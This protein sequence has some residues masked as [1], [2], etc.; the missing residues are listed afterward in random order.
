MSEQLKPCPFCKGKAR[1]DYI[2]GGTTIIECSECHAQTGFMD[3]RAEATEAWNRRAIHE[4]RKCGGEMQP[5]QAIAQTYTGH[6]DFIG[7]EAVTLSPGG[8]GKLVE[9]SKCSAC[10]WSVEK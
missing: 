3:S 2:D 5:G 8:P 7:G 1:Q 9:C 4:C 10:G 6:A